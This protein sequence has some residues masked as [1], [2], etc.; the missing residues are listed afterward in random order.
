MEKYIEKIFSELNIQPMAKGCVYFTVF[1]R[2]DRLRV[3]DNLELDVYLFTEDTDGES[4]TANTFVTD[5]LDECPIQ[6]NRAFKFYAFHHFLNYYEYVIYSDSNVLWLEDMKNLENSHNGIVLFSHNKRNFLVEEINECLKYGKITNEQKH[7]FKA[8]PQYN[9]RAT[10]LLG[11]VFLVRKSQDLKSISRKWERYYR[12]AH[13]DQLGLA[14]LYEEYKTQFTKIDFEVSSQ[15]F[16]RV[17]HLKVP[18]I[19]LDKPLLQRLIIIIKYRILK[20]LNARS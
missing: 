2:Y 16:N 11:S 1:N 14:L 7:K 12:I 17:P 6:S 8:L 15:Y 18:R 19:S 10:L 3:P 9:P 13:R 4:V 5:L 20:L